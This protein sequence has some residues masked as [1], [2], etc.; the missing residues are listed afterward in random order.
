MNY[1]EGKESCRKRSAK[2]RREKGRAAAQG[3]RAAVVIF[4]PEQTAHLPT[5][6]TAHLQSRTFP[7][8]TA[9]GHMGQN[10][11]DKHHG[12][13]PEA[14]RLS[15]LHTVNHIVGSDAFNAC[16][17]VECHNDQACRREQIQHP[18][19][20][21]SQL[22]GA[23]HQDVERR[24]SQPAENAHTDRKD[25]PFCQTFRI[26]CDTPCFFCEILLHRKHSPS[27]FVKSIPSSPVSAALPGK[28]ICAS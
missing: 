7:A 1:R 19:M 26:Y 17:F 27:F 6:V 16:G 10:R 20:G 18:W 8:C 2:Q 23:F 21:H 28:S 4:K 3:C 12:K 25:Q 13:Q 24:T 5:D 11:A 15:V 9:A 14:Q 22:C